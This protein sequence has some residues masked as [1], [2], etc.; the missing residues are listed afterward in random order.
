MEKGKQDLNE[1][2]E[3]FVR[4]IFRD[5]AS[6]YDFVNKV[7]SL[8]MIHRWRRQMIRLASLP[9]EVTI[10][11][12]CT[13]TGKVAELLAEKI[14]SGQVIGVDFSPEMIAI[15]RRRLENKYGELVKFE[16]GNAMELSFPDNT[17][18][19][20]FIAFGLRNVEDIEQ[21]LLEMRR[22]INN[23]GEAFVLDLARPRGRILSALY[24]FYFNQLLPRLDGIIQGKKEAYTYLSRSLRSYPDQDKLKQLFYRTGFKKVSYKELTGGV[25][26]VHR[27]VK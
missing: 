12:L 7:I 14:S 15:A 13:G 10:L 5:I 11:D 22:V 9:P 21:V 18:D 27:G 16:T 8:G 25:V 3:H 20:V 4:Q 19:F 26:T 17:F 23:G 1:T 24:Y 6:S 2:K